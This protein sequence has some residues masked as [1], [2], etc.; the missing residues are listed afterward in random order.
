MRR[1]KILN[2]LNQIRRIGKGTT[3]QNAVIKVT[4]QQIQSKSK[5]KPFLSQTKSKA[6]RLTKKLFIPSRV[7]QFYLLM[8]KTYR[9]VFSQ[10]KFSLSQKLFGNKGNFGILVLRP[11]LFGQFSKV[12][13]VLKSSN[14]QIIMSKTFLFDKTSILEI[15]PQSIQSSKE[16]PEFTPFVANI[17]NGPNKVVI[18]R[19]GTQWPPEK[20]QKI[21]VDMKKH[22]RTSIALPFLK[23]HGFTSKEFDLIAKQLDALGFAES[24]NATEKSLMNIFNGIHVPNVSD[25]PKEALVFLSGKD[26]RQIS[27]NNV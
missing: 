27:K 2:Q 15:Y 10:K 26:L 21:L 13:E 25:M 4:S 22:V 16:Y 12:R 19:W 17:L 23:Q 14:F 8:R 20:K 1:V 24:T 5:G 7:N 9:K 11:E 18:F 3:I 6:Q